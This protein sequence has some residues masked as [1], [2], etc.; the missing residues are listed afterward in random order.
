MVTLMKNRIL[1]SSLA[2]RTAWRMLAS[3]AGDQRKYPRARAWGLLKRED[4]SSGDPR[5]LFRLLDISEEGLQFIVPADAVPC[6]PLEV[7]AQIL[8]KTV[9][10]KGI[11]QIEWIQPFNPYKDCFCVG[12]SFLSIEQPDGEAIRN[13]VIRQIMLS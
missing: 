10:V 11:I 6:E 2:N 5:P 7:S 3:V 12:A 9:Q 8:G 4:G 13:Y 1:E